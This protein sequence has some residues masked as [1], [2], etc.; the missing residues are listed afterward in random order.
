MIDRV[1]VRAR[2]RPRRRILA[3][4]GLRHIAG[5]GADDKIIHRYAGRIRVAQRAARDVKRRHHQ[6]IF[7]LLQGHP[8]VDAG[9]GFQ[10]A[11]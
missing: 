1:A 8:S 2:D 3:R 7:Q 11:P 4:R 5:G 9:P 6:A 10:A